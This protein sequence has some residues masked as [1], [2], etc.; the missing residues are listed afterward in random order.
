MKIALRLREPVTDPVH[1]K[2]VLGGVFRDIAAVALCICDQRDEFY[3]PRNPFTF[4]KEGTAIEGTIPI[5]VPDIERFKRGVIA[6]INE[7][8]ADKSTRE[9]TMVPADL[10]KVQVKTMDVSTQKQTER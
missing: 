1:Q 5:D 2:A 10:P 8:F 4:N 3:S 9:I 7:G 6:S